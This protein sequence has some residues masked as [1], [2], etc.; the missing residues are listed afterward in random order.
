M[1]KPEEL[2]VNATEGLTLEKLQQ[3]KQNFI[4]GE[5]GLENMSP[6]MAEVWYNSLSDDVKQQLLEID[7]ADFE[8][9]KKRVTK[10]G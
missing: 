2:T 7:I 6:S 3:I 8:A 5:T 1:D 10:R 4:D 9:A